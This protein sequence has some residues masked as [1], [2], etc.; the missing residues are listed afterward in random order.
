MFREDHFKK[1]AS[2]LETCK[3]KRLKVSC[4]E[5]CTG[6][7]LAALLTEIP[8]SSAVFEGGFVSYSN[9]MKQLFLNVR[10][11]SLEEYGA[12]SE[13][14]AMEM[15]AH[16]RSVTKTSIA[17]GITGIAGPEGGTTDKPV[18]LVY[19]AVSTPNHAEVKRHVFKGNRSEVRLQAVEHA[20]T[21]IESA[22]AT[23]FSSFA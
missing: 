20:L 16:C 7:L 1:A 19:I 22:L 23:S 17:I 4:A 2:I 9:M 8:G 21:M 6:G 14:V 11:D 3:S 12:V 5:S 18:G 15:A 13:R 10:S